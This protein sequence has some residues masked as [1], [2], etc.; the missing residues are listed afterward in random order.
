MANTELHIR[1]RFKQAWSVVEPGLL[2]KTERDYKRAVALLDYLLDI[3]GEN[4]RH[5]LFGLLE[6]LGMLIEHYEEDH[7]KIRDASPVEVL[8][9]L[10]EEHDLT[11]SDLPEIGSQGVV[12]EI[13]HGKRKLNTHQIKAVS[14]RFGVSPAAF[15]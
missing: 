13:L 11:Q 5:P 12:S 4:E 3:V 15:F 2:I 14:E 9:F 8:R 7:V 1:P 6:V 10:M